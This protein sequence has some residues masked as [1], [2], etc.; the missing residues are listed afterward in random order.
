MTLDD[1][2]SLGE[3]IGGI[4]VVASFLYLAAQVRHSAKAT[5]ASNYD[6]LN[7][8][9]ESILLAIGSD[10]AISTVFTKGMTDYTSLDSDERVRFHMIASAF[11]NRLDTAIHFHEQRVV[12]AE[13]LRGFSAG[14]TAVLSSPCA[15]QWWKENKTWFKPRVQRH[16]DEHLEDGVSPFSADLELGSDPQ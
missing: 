15:A 7:T 3:A 9:F 5:R 13:A 16:L 1:L 8:G 2:G 12:E 11:V 10:S 4:S 14:V 6:S